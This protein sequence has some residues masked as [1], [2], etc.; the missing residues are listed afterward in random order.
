M[1][2]EEAQH[3][4]LGQDEVR[5]IKDNARRFAPEP[6]AFTLVEL[7]VVIAVIG[8][9]A[10]LLLPALSKARARAM[11]AKC[12]ANLRAWGQAFYLYAGDY[13]DYLPHT[14]DEGRNTPPFTYDAKHPEHECCYVDVLPPYMGQRPWRDYP[15]GQKPTDGIWQCPSAKVLPDS[16]YSASFK[17]SSQGYHSYVMNSYLEQDFLF[18]LPY[19]APLQPSFL[20]QEVC[21]ATS[22]TILMFEQTLNP[23]QGY[24]LTGG[25]NTAG[26]YTAEDARAEGERHKRDRGGVGGNV[27]YLDGHVDWR[28]DLWDR[29]L[30][31]PQIPK[32][33]DLTWFPYYY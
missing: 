15:N 25:F 9:L 33:G 26:Q 3:A 5:S 21:A 4:V 11:E 23:S 2:P 32:R 7:L 31:N 22:K 28:N 16:S 18:G 19:G 1:L 13:N 30:T 12:A 17:P 10:G 6:M 24:G 27:L 29:T 14:D 20:K 8:I